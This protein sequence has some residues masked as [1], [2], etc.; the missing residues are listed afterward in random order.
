[1]K[2]L[3][4]SDSLFAARIGLALVILFIVV[5]MVTPGSELQ[6]RNPIRKTFFSTYPAAEGTALDNLPSNS[7]HCGVCHFDFG[8]GG[9]RNPYGLAV[10][11]GLNNGLS[12]EEAILAAHNLDSDS[13]GYKNYIEAGD[14][15]NFSNTPTFPGLYE[16]NRNNVLN[17]DIADIIPYLT[18]SGATDTISPSV[19]LIDPDGAEVMQ[20]GSYYSVN[21]TADD[22]SGISHINIYHSDDGGTTFVPVGSN[23]PTGTGFSWFV[24]NYP[25]ISNRIKVEAFDNAGNRGS[26]FSLGDF[27][28]TATPAG[29]VPS[30]L[31]DMEMPGTQPHE[32]AILED[33]DISCATCHGNYDPEAEPWYNWRGSMMGQAARDPLFL[34]CMTV[35]EQDAPSVGDLCIRCHFPGGW[36]EGR[37]VDTSGEML[38]VRDRH[39]VHCDFCHRI[40]DFDYKEGVSPQ[41][42]VGVLATVDPLPLQYGNGQFINDPGPVKRGPYSDAEA[43]HDFVES[44]IHRSGDLCGTCHDVSSPVFTQTSSDDYTPSGFDE[45][46]PD[47]SIRNMM[48]IERTYSEWKM[49]EYASSGV[50]APQFAGNKPDGIVSSCQD[51]HMRDVYAKG[52]N[53]TGVNDR[54]DLALHDLTGG[55]TFIPKMI[56]DYFPDEVDAAQLNDAVTR[57]RSM[58]E[59]AATLEVIPEDFGISVKVTNETAHKLPSGYPEG[60]RIWI[61]IKALDVTGQTIYE[62]GRYDYAEALLIEDPRIKI[63][64]IHPGLSPSLASALG[65]PEGKSFHFVLNDTIYSDNRIPP[66]G[67]TNTAFEE[68]QSPAVACQYEDGQYWDITPYNLPLESDSVIV[69]L[70]YQ[71]TTREYVEFLRDENVTNSTGQ[72]LYNSWVEHG[73]SAPEKMASIRASVNVT[74]TGDDDNPPLVF[75]MDQNYPN[76]FNPAT[77]I[78]YSVAEQTHVTIA[79]FDVKGQRV[80]TLVDSEHE[81]SRYTAKWDGKNESGSDVSSGI[82]F[83]KY[84]AGDHLFTRKAVLLR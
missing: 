13:D 55:N 10:E 26:D 12:N 51:C 45:K 49:S 9:Q 46:H 1:M 11:I 37:S 68:I 54:A 2:K 50:F 77:V 22:P 33:P 71:T 67:F 16:G 21:F 31:R 58:L 42:D 78:G 4:F 62:S 40:V 72:D 14:I 76:P 41:A 39:G 83:I 23:E 8:G 29:Y 24:P 7:G 59:K 20:A 6:A 57:A 43:S 15:V 5:S 64:E 79:V 69:T 84:R 73:K 81:P 38:T 34:A 66:R 35:A 63:Y 70:F 36:Q 18:P 60:R 65:L 19:D 53:Q 25:G 75:G 17:V 52:A 48:P 28:I 56:S 44:P 74:L 82:Y 3:C 32:G 80:R 30:T 61:N 47:M 27:S